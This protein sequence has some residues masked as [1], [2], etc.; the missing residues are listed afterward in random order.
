[1]TVIKGGFGLA[2]VEFGTGLVVARLDGHR[3]SAPSAIG[4]AGVSWGA[5][6]GAQVSDHVFFLMTDHAVQMMFSNEGSV[7]LGADLGVAVGPL[8]R[9][10]EGN[11]GATAGSVAPIYSYSLSKGLYAGVSVDGKVIVTRNGVNEKFYG[12]SK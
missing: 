9:A 11:L 3:W 4:T 10:V 5:L 2:G 12:R 7:Q 8:G 1:M 6:L